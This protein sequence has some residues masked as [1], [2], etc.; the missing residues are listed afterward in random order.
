MRKPV[1]N[2]TWCPNLGVR[3]CQL[4]SSISGNNIF[5]FGHDLVVF[6]RDGSLYKKTAESVTKR[7]EELGSV[8]SNVLVIT[9]RPGSG[10]RKLKL[11]L[12]LSNSD[13]S[14]AVP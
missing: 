5:K 11:L 12:K 3:R 8:F 2:G 1:A 13:E 6:Q 4:V 14:Q 7:R 10:L 9:C